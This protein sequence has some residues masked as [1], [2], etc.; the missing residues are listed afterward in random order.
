MDHRYKPTDEVFFVQNAGNPDAGTGL[1]KSAA[2]YKISLKEADAVKAERN[3][4]GK[5][6][7]SLAQSNPEV[8]NPNGC[9]QYKGQLLFAAEGQGDD[10]PASLIV[11]NP[12]EP[13]N[14]TGKST[15]FDQNHADRS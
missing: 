10:K 2:I 9:V 15:A 3:A 5:V 8:P 13:Y 4:T 12:R 11:M 1:K 7:V 14:T 6:K